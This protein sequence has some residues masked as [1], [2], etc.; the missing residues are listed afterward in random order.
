MKKVSNIDTSTISLSHILSAKSAT[1]EVWIDI[2]DPEKS[3]EYQADLYKN[4]F[5][6]LKILCG[7]LSPIVFERPDIIEAL[8]KFFKNSDDG[9]L[10]IIFSKQTDKKEN[11]RDILVKENKKLM[12]N[13]IIEC[14]YLIHREGLKNILLWQIPGI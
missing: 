7:E 5:K 9:K 2:G 8:T 11:V 12:K 1:N 13:T 6:E 10:K 3:I 4:A 14:L